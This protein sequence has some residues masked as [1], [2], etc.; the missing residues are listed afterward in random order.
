M[1]MHADANEYS[2]TEAMQVSK[3]EG[4]LTSLIHHRIH[5]RHHVR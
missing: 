5:A 1:Q 2:V 4:E 3:W